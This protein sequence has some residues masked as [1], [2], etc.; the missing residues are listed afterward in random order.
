MNRDLAA[1]FQGMRDQNASGQAVTQSAG[2]DELA[3][4]D[5]GANATPD[6]SLVQFEGQRVAASVVDRAAAIKDR[7]PSLKVVSGHRDAQQNQRENGVDRSWHLK[8]RA[9]D[10]RGP[11][12]D[13]YQAAATAQMLGAAEAL[14]HNNGNGMVLHVA[15][16]D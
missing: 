4:P 12:A 1:Q 5:V 6:E 7:H 15:W 3:V 11:V 8:G 13:L 14:V 2:A 9:V 10:Y 16:S